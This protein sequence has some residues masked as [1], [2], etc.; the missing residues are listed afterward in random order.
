[1]TTA[2]TQTCLL[3]DGRRL[4]FAEY[5]DPHGVPVISLHGTPGGALLGRI[6]HDAWTRQGLRVITPERPGYGES[7]PAPGRI[8]RSCADDVVALLDALNLERVFVMGGSGGGPHAL[9]VAAAAPH[10][11][12]AVGVL[13]GA[14]PLLPEEVSLQVEVN[15]RIH[16]ALGDMERLRAVVGPVRDAFV[17]RGIEQVLQ[18]APV[19]DKAQ[20]ATVAETMNAAIGSA[21]AP[22]IEGMVDDFVALWGSP[23]GF[24]PADVTVP[25]LWASGA[26]DR[27]V[28]LAA[29]LRVVDQLPDCRLV[30]WDHVGHAPSPELHAEFLT[31]LLARAL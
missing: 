19:S 1:M 22:G 7:D 29:A 3:P 6:R 14:A 26:A 15:Q 18:D 28:P 25:V 8:V 17:E 9:G 11:V 16:A 20:W 5:G 23:W 10:R 2:T 4:A 13:V 31:G 24:D 12:R 21:L 27:N 30:V